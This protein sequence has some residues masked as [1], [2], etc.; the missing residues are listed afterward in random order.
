MLVLCWVEMEI[1]K[2]EITKTEVYK[3]IV[4]KYKFEGFFFV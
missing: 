3:K 2:D 1:G 4:Q